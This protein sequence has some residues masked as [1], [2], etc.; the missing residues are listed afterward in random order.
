MM[1]YVLGQS[2]G[3]LTVSTRPHKT[4]TIMKML[5]SDVVTTTLF[6]IPT[7]MVQFILIVLI[8]STEFIPGVK[9]VLLWRYD[10]CRTSKD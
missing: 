3:W 1:C 10:N 9:I 5:V 4:A 7:D 2:P 8:T 6:L